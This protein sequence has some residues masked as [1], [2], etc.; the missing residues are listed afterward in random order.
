MREQRATPRLE[1]QAAARLQA[2]GKSS[3]QNGA[4]V[5]VTVV[6]SSDRGMRLYSTAAMNTGQA[7]AVEIGEAMFLGEVCYCA[8]A[9]AG[10]GF[11]LGIHVRECLTGLASLHHLIQALSPQLVTEPQRQR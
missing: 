1:V 6:D 3:D 8:P 11:F 5:R 2:L 7:V 9:P 4:P 10:E